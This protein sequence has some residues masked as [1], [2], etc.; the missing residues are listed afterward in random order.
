MDFMMLKSDEDDEV[1]N[2]DVSSLMCLVLISLY[3]FLVKLAY[4]F[5]LSFLQIYLI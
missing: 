4:V 3:T 1:R 5:T 2:S